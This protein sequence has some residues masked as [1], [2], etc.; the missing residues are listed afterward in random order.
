MPIIESTIQYQL[1][2]A[3]HI[4]NN[5]SDAASLEAEVM[6][7]HVLQLSR[8]YLYAWP[9]Y[10]LQAED[11]AQFKTYVARRARHEPIAYILGQKEFWSLN[12]SVNPTVLIPR[13]ETEE[14]IDLILHVKKENLEL[15]VADLGTG[16]GA[17]ALAL[18]YERPNWLIYATDIDSSAL[19]LAQQNA[20]KLNLHN[21]SFYQGNWFEGLPDISCDVI[22]SN[23]PYIAEKEWD[24]YAQ[25]LA[26]EPK[27]ALVSGVEGLDAIHHIATRAKQYLKPSGY[28]FIEHGFLQGQAVRSLFHQ[29]GY[30]YC[31]SQRDLSGQERITW[32]YNNHGG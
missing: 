16:S 23:P 24:I 13:S 6:L 9:S 3:K 10:M 28:L 32:G 21:L 12:L 11:I 22:V 20:Q 8:S 18:A 30:H 15:T 2:Y 1:D 31:Y 26:Y 7:A 27:H 14:L 19:T 25:G 29:A 5:V 4:L 17:I